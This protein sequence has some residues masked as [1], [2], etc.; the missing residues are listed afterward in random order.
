MYKYFTSIIFTILIISCVQDKDFRLAD[1]NVVPLPQ[2]IKLTEGDPFI[3][4]KST[5]IVYQKEN[6]SH[7]I[8]AE[9]LAKDLSDITGY[10]INI[11]ESASTLTN[12]IFLKN[13][14]ENENKE[15]YTLSINKDNMTIDGSSEAGIF[16]AIQTLRKSIPTSAK[17]Y[18]EF[19]AGE[20]KDFPY[21]KHRGA[22][23]DVSRH[24]FSADFVKKYIDVLALCN[25]NVF[26]WHLTDDQGWRIEIKKYPKLTEIGSQRDSTIIG[27]HTATFDHTPHGGYYTQDE[28][29][30]IV[31]YAAQRHITVIPEIDLPGH[32]LAAL[33]SYPELGCTGGPYTVGSEWGIYEDALCAGNEDVFSFLDNVFSEV[34]ELFPSQYIHIGGDECLKNRWM[35]CPKC[36]SRM[37]ELRLHETKEHSLG[38]QLQSYFIAR[39]EKMINT[40]GKQ[41]IGWDEILEGGIAP[42]ATIMSW[43]G[44][45]GGIYAANKGHDVIMTPEAYLYLDY[46]QSPDVD[47]E[48]F[49]FGWLT[50]L[51]KVYSYNPMPA[52]LN[53]NSKKHIQGAQVNIWSEYMPTS[54][55]V[56]YMLLPRMAALAETLWTNP[57]KKDY[58]NFVSR[59]YNLSEHFDRLGYENCKQ[60]YGVQD[61][62]VIDTTMNEI[63]I[64]LSTFDNSPIYYTTNGEEP[65]NKSTLYN[66]PITINNDMTIKAISGKNKGNPYTKKFV[67]HKAIAKPIQLKHEPASRYSFNGATTLVDGQ[68]GAIT[69]YRTGTRIGFLGTDMEAIIDMKNETE[70]SSVVINCFVNTRGDLFKMKRLTI[71]TS[72]NGKDYK[73]IYNDTYPIPGKDVSP[74]IV[75]IDAK[76]TPIK[77]RYVKVIAESIKTLPDWHKKKGQKAYLM[78]DEIKVY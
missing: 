51:K 58:N 43:R 24:F 45:E 78:I 15:S 27:R 46:Y 64:Y 22:S 13:T 56:E 5:K 61:S 34:A 52:G 25:M 60:A 69:S 30:D 19:P 73:Q 35:E 54:K 48:P 41:I 65:T 47:K 44:T 8:L 4:N 66:T 6:N 70:I 9:F 62:I 21:Y 57:E 55:N 12:N 26:H 76:F 39:I 2:E 75:S 38:E 11:G 17:D 28:I 18:I 42:N 37:K 49:T 74:M 40:K 7:R 67:S 3:L 53:I 33:A 59:L 77:T 16:Y 10:T 71:L 23:L 32:M 20:I 68:L 1:Y 31:A 63:R 72:D 14:L 50:D 29:K 36:K